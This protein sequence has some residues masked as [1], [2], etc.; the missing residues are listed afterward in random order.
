MENNIFPENS[1]IFLK[2]MSEGDAGF[3]FLPLPE[4]WTTM[5]NSGMRIGSAMKGTP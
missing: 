5:V 4:G 2:I 1:S 3:P